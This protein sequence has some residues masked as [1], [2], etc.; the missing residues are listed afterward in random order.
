MNF[1]LLIHFIIHEDIKRGRDQFGWPLKLGEG[2]AQILE[3][4]LTEHVEG[5]RFTVA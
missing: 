5:D 3:Q 1:P 2:T 4:Q